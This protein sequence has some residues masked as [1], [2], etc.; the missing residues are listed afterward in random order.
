M[1]P[2]G[3]TARN[4][5]LALSACLALIACSRHYVNTLHPEYGQ[6]AFDSDWYECQ[7]ENTHSASYVSPYF[8]SSGAEVDYNMAQSC[9]RARG[10]QPGTAPQ[11]SQ[12]AS[13]STT[14][15]T[16]MLDLKDRPECDWGH[17]YSSVKKQCVK[18][19]SE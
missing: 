1:T 5:A 13:S 14:Q 10:W 12:P 7:R 2:P 15:P 4:L 9:M 18:I 16:K 8:G 3:N 17:Y 6:T 11:M 19:G